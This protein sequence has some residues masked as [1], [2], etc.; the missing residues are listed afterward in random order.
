VMLVFG[1]HVTERNRPRRDDPA[2]VHARRVAKQS[3]Q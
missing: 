3:L 1:D 2:Q